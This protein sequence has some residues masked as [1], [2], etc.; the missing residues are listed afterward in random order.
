[1]SDPFYD[2]IV[3]GGGHAG[4]EAAYV[5][6]RMGCVV[7]LLTSQLD[8]IGRASCN[9]AVGGIGKGQIVREI[10]A[11]GGLMGKIADKT[12]IHRR[13]LN[14]SKGPSVW[15]PRVQIDKAE[16]S[17]EMKYFLE[18]CDNL[19]FYQ[20]TVSQIF[21]N[22]GTITGIGTTDHLKFRCG[23]LI[24][25]SGTFSRGMVYVGTDYRTKEGRA[26]ERSCHGLSRQLEEMGFSF[27][28]LKTGT[29][30]RVLK[31]EIDFSQL[32]EQR[33]DEDVWFS[34]DGPPSH[35][36]P[37]E[38][39]YITYTTE[40]TEQCIRSYLHLSPAYT[41]EIDSQGP[42]YCPSIEEKFIRYPSAKRHRV[43]IE[44]EGRRTGEIYLNGIST[45]LPYRVQEEMVRSI[46]G[47]KRCRILRPAYVV[48]YDAL[49]H[50]Q[51]KIS[52]ESKG[53]SGLFFAGQINGTTGYEEAAGQGIIAGI[54]A[55][56]HVKEENSYIPLRSKSYIGVMLDDLTRQ[57]H[58]EPYRMFTS[59]AEHRL[60]LRQDNADLR[61]RKDGYDLGIVKESQYRKTQEKEDII[62]E[63]LDWIQKAKIEGLPMQKFL[64]RPEVS[65]SS[66]MEK[67]TTPQVPKDVALH[68][69]ATFIYSGYIERQEKVIQ[70]LSEAENVRIPPSLDYNQIVGLSREEKEVLSSSC[71]ITFGQASRLPGISMNTINIL[72]VAMKKHDEMDSDAPCVHRRATPH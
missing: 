4:C 27:Y 32:E 40:Q 43:F 46:T 49:E 67:G 57:H 14:T 61:L 55:A 48:E 47:L 6:S 68:I 15:S 12:S 45:W 18:G 39:C 2:V 60:V 63:T 36:F 53:Y 58:R 5:A 30:P 11:L 21:H 28:R 34:Y 7:L 26:G 9:P 24:I 8:S 59:R 16:Y 20:G 65:Y 38:P 44:P 10:D 29:P 35:P 62:Q 13:M 72:R 41:K 66:L 1:M 56:N 37:T 64:L 69:D 19:Y 25:C 54:N 52:L 17:I 51:I 50:G 22:N 33:G 42:R 71:P 23:S 3:V 31:K 70:D